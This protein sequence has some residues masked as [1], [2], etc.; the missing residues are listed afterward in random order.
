MAGKRNVSCNP[1]AHIS[2]L[3]GRILCSSAGV[4]NGFVKLTVVD[5]LHGIKQVP[6]TSMLRKAICA[7]TQ[8]ADRGPGWRELSCSLRRCRWPAARAWRP[9]TCGTREAEPF[10]QFRHREIDKR[11]KLERYLALSSVHEVD[12]RRQRF[13]GFQK[14][15]E[16]T[17]FHRFFNLVRHYPCNAG[18]FRPATTAASTELATSREG[19]SIFSVR[20]LD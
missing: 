10:P 7:T 19:T 20:P 13:E 11:P 18:R 16:M 1:F 4:C 9:R 2:C 3:F 5:Y 15:H 17:G 8:V 6:L 12:R 14:L